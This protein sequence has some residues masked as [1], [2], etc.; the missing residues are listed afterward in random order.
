MDKEKFDN[1]I[2][3]LL[4]HRKEV[5]DNLLV[6]CKELK[7]RGFRHDESK[8]KDPELDSYVNIIPLMKDK[9]YGTSDYKDII[10]QIKPAVDHHFSVNSHHPQFYKEGLGGMDLVDLVEMF[11]DWLAASKRNNDGNIQK[12]ILFNKE[13]FDIPEVLCDIMNN[14]AKRI[15]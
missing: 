4:E 2:N 3:D 6:F 5:L 13:K 14:T 9:K 11:C 15:F 1:G 7:E 12:S 10:K 8:F